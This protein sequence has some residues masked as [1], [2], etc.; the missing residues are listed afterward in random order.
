M[1]LFDF[2]A[3]DI[4]KDE[5]GNRLHGIN[6]VEELFSSLQ[7]AFLGTHPGKD[8]L[9]N[10][11]NCKNQDQV[12]QI[13]TNQNLRE[14]VVLFVETE[15]TRFTVGTALKTSAVEGVNVFYGL[16]NQDSF[17]ISS[18]LTPPYLCVMYG[19]SRIAELKV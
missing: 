18:F 5:F 10:S 13:L 15:P 2:S 11:W 4:D 3:A 19:H 7:Q 16:L 12:E 9:S 14:S 1:L 8:R 6:V 17:S